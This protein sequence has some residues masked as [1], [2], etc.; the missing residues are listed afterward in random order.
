MSQQDSIR[1]A[2]QRGREAMAAAQAARPP[3]GALAPA[4]SAVLAAVRWATRHQHTIDDSLATA[5]EA[6]A[7][8]LERHTDELRRIVAHLGG[9]SEGLGRFDER[10][11]SLEKRAGRAEA[12]IATV[13]AD[14]HALREALRVPAT[15]NGA[16]DDVPKDG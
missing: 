3:S 9:T 4:K 1:S 11:T 7:A 10:I 12:M 6:A 16:G 13:A 2:L 5:V 8:D 14:V 15:A